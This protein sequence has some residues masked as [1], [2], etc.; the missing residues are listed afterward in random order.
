MPSQLAKILFGED[1]DVEVN[2]EAFTEL[3]LKMAKHLKPEAFELM[4]TMVRRTIMTFL[5]KTDLPDK[6]CDQ[7][8]NGEAGTHDVA[9]LYTANTLFEFA[10]PVEM[11]KFC[12]FYSEWAKFHNEPSFSRLEETPAQ[13]LN[14][15][16]ES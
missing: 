4:V 1:T 2:T 5:Q 16:L 15:I 9:Q 14:R 11:M 8:L 7:F 12:G 6:V 13:K 3:E 10:S